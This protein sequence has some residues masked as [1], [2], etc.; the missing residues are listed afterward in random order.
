MCEGLMEPSRGVSILAIALAILWGVL[1]M[2]EIMGLIGIFCLCVFGRP[3]SLGIR[4][5]Y[6]MIVVQDV[7]SCLIMFL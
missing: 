6:S 4:G 7:C 5:W 2:L 1:F 3:Y